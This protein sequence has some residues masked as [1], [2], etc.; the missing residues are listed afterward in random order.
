[1]GKPSVPLFA[2]RLFPN[3][4]GSPLR[5]ATFPQILNYSVAC[6]AFCSACR[7]NTPYQTLRHA[8]CKSASG[9]CRLETPFVGLCY[10]RSECGGIKAQYSPTPP[11]PPLGGKPVEGEIKIHRFQL[12]LDRANDGGPALTHHRSPVPSIARLPSLSV[13]QTPSSSKIVVRAP[14]CFSAFKSAKDCT[15]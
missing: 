12:F 2:N 9:S 10:S 8:L 7:T 1:M 13:T 3:R 14:S 15:R 11:L 6:L 5:A 4:S